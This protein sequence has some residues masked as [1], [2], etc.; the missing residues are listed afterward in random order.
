MIQPI[1]PSSL[2]QNIFFTAA[3]DKDTDALLQKVEGIFDGAMAD[4]V[5]TDMF[6]STEGGDL[7]LI[8]QLENKEVALSRLSKGNILLQVADKESE[9]VDIFYHNTSDYHADKFYRYNDTKIYPWNK[10][11]D[12]K[13]MSGFVFNQNTP[14]KNVVEEM[15]KKYIPQFLETLNKVTATSLPKIHL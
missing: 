5:S 2:K 4:T 8:K 15:C 11:R 10:G 7:D 6:V 12:I 13:L 9:T 14:K 1:A 3:Y